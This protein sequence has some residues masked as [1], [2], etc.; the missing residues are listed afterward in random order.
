M[1]TSDYRDMLSALSNAEVD[2][3][4]VGAFALAAHGNPRATG[5]MDIYIR[6]ELSN[7]ERLMKALGEF[8]APVS[9][10]SIDDFL[11]LDTDYQ[12]GISPCRIDLLTRLDGIENF[13]DAWVDHIIASVDGIHI[14]VL[15]RR[16]LIQNK[17]CLAR[18]QDIADV[19]WLEANPE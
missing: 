2:C 11:K 18:P 14:P 13:E 7:A 6:P 10:I 3:L 16:A 5:D 12:I 8:G 4:V 9:K 1:L 19:A 17:K 15:S